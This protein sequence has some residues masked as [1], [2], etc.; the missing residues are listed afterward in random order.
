[1]KDNKDE[2]S[3]RGHRY[4]VIMCGGVGSRFWPFS[5]TALPKQ[6]L[7]FFGTGR[8][9][10]QMTVDRITPLVDADHIIIV[11][12]ESYS[13]LVE[14]Q[15]PQIK[16]SNILLEPARRNTSPCVCWASHHIHALDPE[17]TVLTLPSDHLILHEDVFRRD[18]EEGFE[19]VEA[20]E[21]LLTLGIKPS[22]AHTGYGYIQLGDQVS[23][24]SGFRKVKSFTEKPDIEMARIFLDS[25]EFYWNSGM[26]LWKVSDILKAYGEHAPETNALF[27]A[28]EG[29][30]GTP[31]ERKFIE[32]VFPSAPSIS[33]DYDIMEKS[34]NV[35]VKTVDFGWSDLG[36]WK[37]LYDISPRTREGNVVQNCKIISRD[38]NG[39][40]FAVS[41]DKIVVAS[42]LKDYIV[43]DNG[44]ALLICPLA[45]EQ[46]LRQMVN[47]V[48]ERFGEKYV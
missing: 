3:R 17:A 42:G 8:S 41:G 15:L 32:T 34:P 45:E 36:S 14:E 13:G 22:S 28:E 25:G 11:T 12:N 26:F 46:K 19:F 33:I 10:L 4:C 29:V 5:R 39:S 44:N 7:D 23:G 24:E 20:G 48:S 37:A 31:E 6:F 1:M 38:C 43:A 47:D 2:V 40:V 35:Y 30:Y 9:L 18:I 21:R 27:E 16:G